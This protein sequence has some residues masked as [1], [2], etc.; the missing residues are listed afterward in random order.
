MATLLTR[1]TGAVRARTS[2][3]LI[4]TR[5]TTSSANEPGGAV[6]RSPFSTEASVR[7]IMHVRPIKPEK[8]MH[9]GNASVER[10]FNQIGEIECR[11]GVNPF[12]VARDNYHSHRGDGFPRCRSARLRP[13]STRRAC[14]LKENLR[15]RNG[16]PPLLGEMTIVE[17]LTR[18]TLTLCNEQFGG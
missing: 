3:Q 10:H 9:R 5:S 17:P 13:A 8:I 7:A 18:T 4:P 16:W 2:V 15:L 6:G 12:G 11:L 14:G 1:R